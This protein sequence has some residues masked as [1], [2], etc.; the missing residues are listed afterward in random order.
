MSTTVAPPQT[1]TELLPF[2]ADFI[3]Q[4]EIVTAPERKRRVGAVIPAYQEEDSIA[5]VLDGLLSQTRMPDEIHV[6]VNN[7]TDDTFYIARQ[8]AGRHRRRYR[9]L[10]QESI[11]RIHDVGRLEERKV[12]ALNIGFSMVEHCDYMIGVD[13]DTVLRPDAVERLLEEA[14]SDPR[15]G[16]ISAI[17]S[18]DHD[19]A[20]GPLES[21][22]LTG[23][24]Q[25]FASFNLLNLLRGRNMAV[26]GGQCSIFSIR[27]LAAVRDQY[28]QRGPWVSDSE[29]EDSLLSL[30]LKRL[31]FSTKISAS[32]RADVGP[33]LTLKSLD[34]QQVKW[35]YGGIDLMWPGQRGN[36]SGQPFHPNLRLRW[37]EN[38][39]MLLNVLVRAGFVLL[40]LAALS[41]NALVFSPLWLIPPALAIM[42]NVRIALTMHDHR[43]RDVLFALLFLPAEL[44]LWIRM[45]HFLR[46]WTQF[47]SHQEQDNWAAQAAAEKG[48]GKN[49]YLYPLAL[50]LVALAMMIG[51]WIAMPINVQVNVLWLAWPMQMLIT[52][53]LCGTMVKQLLRR[54]RGYRV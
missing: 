37:W 15:I 26:L 47:L 6:V 27:A 28:R 46:A 9:D 24:R 38:W 52:L 11:V 25:Q 43:A 45:G 5:A 1:S 41:I 22:L 10:E 3:H 21:F 17:Y 32:A 12:G 54:H 36:T 39:V 48:R 4:G 29:V 34:A 44:Y 31:G 40:V 42:L 13:G 53:L 14:E 30:Q 49:V 2:D 18:I 8:Y 20:K 35:N 7:C 51:V 33:M 19:E 50:S 16:G 23:Q